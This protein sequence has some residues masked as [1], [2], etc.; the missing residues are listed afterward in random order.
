[1]PPNTSRI[2]IVSVPA[3]YEALRDSVGPNRVNQVLLEPTSDLP[4]LKQVIAEVSAAHQGKLLFI[5]G[6]PGSGKTSLAECLAIYLGNAVGTVLT[7]PPDFQLPLSELPKWIAEA[8]AKIQLPSQKLIVVNLDGREITSSDEAATVAAMTNLNA[9]LRRTPD[10][11]LLWPIINR[12]FADN[13]IEQLSQVGGQTALSQLRVHQV[14]GIAKDRYYDVLDLIL[15]T[16]GVTLAD[17]AMSIDEARGRVDGSKNLGDYLEAIQAL[18]VSRYDLGELGG[19]L[20]RISFVVS[21]NAD[22]NPI[23]RMLRRG[24]G[25]LID[26]DRL[27]QFSRANIADDWRSRAG[28]N[29]RHALPFIASLFDAKLLS[30]SSSSVV[31]ACA[32]AEDESLG[33][34]V[35]KHYPNPV[36]SNAWNS[37]VNSSL[38]R[39]LLGQEDVGRSTSQPSAAI[40]LAYKD[41]QALSKT[42]HR[43]LNEAIMRVVAANVTGL[44]IPQ[45]ESTPVAGK[46]LRVDVWLDRSDRPETLEFTHRADVTEAVVSSYILTKIQDYARDYGLI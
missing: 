21:S 8:R 25:Y 30:V 27:L 5:Q 28:N 32:F 31:N 42:K 16:M 46:E 15:R 1:M 29:A 37:M 41:L 36:S 24:N 17:A 40:Q 43:A 2:G 4:A 22:A 35:R 13:A 44:P 26:P 7:S 39:S 34:I 19:K 45:F 9:L 6:D 33:Q 38:A 11:L 3:R 23:C 20:P 18:V 14:V 10:M 12:S